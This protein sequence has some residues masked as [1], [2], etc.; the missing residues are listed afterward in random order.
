LVR[1]DGRQAGYRYAALTRFYAGLL[2][3][4]REIPGVRAASAS[5]F[6]LVAHYT[7][8]G[9]VVIVGR[10]PQPS[11]PSADFLEID[12]AFLETMQ[13]PM[14][15]GRNLETADLASPK[16]AVVNQKFASIFFGTENPIGRRF[17]LE[18][19]VRIEIVGVAKTAHYNSLQE[20][21]SPVIYLPYTLNRVGHRCRGPSQ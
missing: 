5:S 7:N 11:D 21:S 15:L 12:P 3:R 6:P 19:Q 1:I 18:K 10:T 14:L 8:N 20:E 4:F 2:D 17:W 13:I 16:V 9:N